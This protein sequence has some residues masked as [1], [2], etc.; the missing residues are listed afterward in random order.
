MSTYNRIG[1]I[2]FLSTCNC[3]YTAASTHP[4]LAHVCGLTV[5]VCIVPTAIVICCHPCEESL[6]PQVQLFL[7]A[8]KCLKF[9]SQRSAA[10]AWGPAWPSIFRSILLLPRAARCAL[11]V[12]FAATDSIF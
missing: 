6:S 12:S 9:L 2:A 4:L 7:F 8:I 1:P 3:C 5:D 10:V 11:R